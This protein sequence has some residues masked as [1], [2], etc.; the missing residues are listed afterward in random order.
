MN[1]GTGCQIRVKMKKLDFSIGSKVIGQTKLDYEDACVT[2]QN[3][4]TRVPVHA[5]PLWTPVGP[6]SLP[7]WST[8]FH[9]GKIVSSMS[10]YKL[11]FL[12]FRDLVCYTLFLMLYLL[13]PI[14]YTLFVIPYLLY[15]ICY[16]L[17]ARPY[18]INHISLSNLFATTDSPDLVY[19][20]HRSLC[21]V[22]LCYEGLI[23]Y[24]MLII[25]CQGISNKPC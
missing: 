21:S 11:P 12:V 6:E 20:I 23:W 3:P 18:L 24:T 7:A 8:N 10:I 14:C 2:T 1:Q 4:K 17:F 15:P 9:W 16:T 19:P 5:V 22:F 25:P 13:Y